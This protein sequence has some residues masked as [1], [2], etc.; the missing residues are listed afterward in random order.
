MDVREARAVLGVGEAS[1]W[2]DVRAAYR[3]LIRD[4]HPD[5]AG[6]GGARRAA[7]INDAYTSLARVRR[8]A[9][10][11]TTAPGPRTSTP[12]AAPRP[13][14]AG[15]PV[16]RLDGATIR[17][18][19]PPDHAFAHLMEAAHAFGEITYVDRSCGIFEAVVPIAGEGACSLVVS[20]T[21]TDRG[22][23]AFC[24]LEAI[25]RVAQ[26]PVHHLVEAMVEVLR[27]G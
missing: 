4:V 19:C 26:P 27:G 12:A 21:A 7:R 14:P 17:L 25:E 16:E 13:V 23:D 9:S 24:T 18:A 20:L 10:T 11:A 6:P 1:G 3:R 5:L 2:D 15:V 8:N 22:T